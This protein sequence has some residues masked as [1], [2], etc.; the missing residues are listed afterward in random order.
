MINTCMCIYIHMYIH[1]S[2]PTSRRVGFDSARFEKRSEAKRSEA[3][4]SEARGTTHMEN[5]TNP[6]CGPSKSTFFNAHPGLPM[7]LLPGTP[8]D[9]LARKPLSPYFRL[10]NGPQTLFKHYSNSLS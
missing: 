7:N 4:R 8:R 2:P 1:T 5:P 10:I 6:P 9:P 3:K